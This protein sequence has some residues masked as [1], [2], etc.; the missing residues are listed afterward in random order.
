MAKVSGNMTIKMVTKRFA[1]MAM[2]DEDKCVVNLS[3]VDG[4]GN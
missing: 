2:T 1:S 4:E 3:V